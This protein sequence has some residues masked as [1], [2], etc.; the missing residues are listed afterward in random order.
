MNLNTN[1]LTIAYIDTPL[2]KM[3]AISDNK[4]LFLLEF[5]DKKNLKQEIEKIK[6][7]SKLSLGS[8][9]PIKGITKELNLYFSG[10]LQS[11]TT[12][13]S[14]T[15]SKFQTKAWQELSKIPYGKTISYSTQAQSMKKEKAFRAVANANGANTLVII[16]PCHR[17]IGSNGKMG[18][19]SCGLQRKQWLLDHEKK[20]SFS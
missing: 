1:S 10:N 7:Q 8:T 17:V 16:I 20:Y 14:F 9:T 5:I 2:G 13:V 19:Y 3:C 12:T 18:G 6:K 4:S 11:F 15:G